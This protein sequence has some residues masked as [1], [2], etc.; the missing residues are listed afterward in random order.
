[1]KQKI[2]TADKIVFFHPLSQ[3]SQDSLS[4]TKKKKKKIYFI[5]YFIERNNQTKNKFGVLR[6]KGCGILKKSPSNPSISIFQYHGKI[7]VSEW[8]R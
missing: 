4:L 6:D 3:L 2:N 1:M 7:P 5:C 8:Y